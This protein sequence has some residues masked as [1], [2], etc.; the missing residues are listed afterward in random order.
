MMLA[1]EGGQRIL[2]A[3]Y[4]R[5][6]KTRIITCEQPDYEGK[7]VGEGCNAQGSAC[8]CSVHAVG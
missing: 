7:G 3:F 6:S 5:D 1:E 2:L 4:Q 8:I